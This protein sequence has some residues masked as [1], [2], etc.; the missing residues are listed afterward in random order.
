MGSRANHIHHNHHTFKLSDNFIA[1]G[2]DFYNAFGAGRYFD[3]DHDSE[4]AACEQLP[5]RHGAQHQR[6]G[7]DF[8]QRVGFAKHVVREQ[9]F[10]E[11]DGQHFAQREHLDECLVAQLSAF[12]FRKHQRSELRSGQRIGRAAVF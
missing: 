5:G 8:D 7:D 6:F 2:H 4:H 1:D 9:H 10:A 3:H 11:R 12:D